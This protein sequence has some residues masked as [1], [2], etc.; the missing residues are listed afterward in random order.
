MT[1]SSTNSIPRRIH[2]RNR[3]KVLVI[4]VAQ[5]FSSVTQFISS[6]L[7]KL[8]QQVELLSPESK[9]CVQ[10]RQ[11]AQSPRS[12]KVSQ[13][14][15]EQ[16][17][18]CMFVQMKDNILQGRTMQPWSTVR[19]RTS[20]CCCNAFIREATRGKKKKHKPNHTWLNYFILN[21]IP[22]SRSAVIDFHQV[23]ETIS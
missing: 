10:K 19:L 3:C 23:T 12:T 6:N 4:N 2:T 21:A 14:P 1:F 22:P 20:C 11:F 5:F 8:L 13:S 15:G 17:C 7:Q 18:D 16:G 9:P